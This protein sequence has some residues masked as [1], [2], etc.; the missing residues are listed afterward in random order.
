MTFKT[1]KKGSQNSDVVTMQVALRMMG[2]RGKDG[3]LLTIDGQCGD[4][5]I[6]AINSFQ[7]YTK[8]AGVNCGNKD[9]TFG[10]NCWKFITGG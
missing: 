7:V 2:F 4:N 3:K 8:S 10:A 6:Y 5:S 9:S 1:I